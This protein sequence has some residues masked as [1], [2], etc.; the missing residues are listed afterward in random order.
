MTQ[1]EMLDLAGL[2]LSIVFTGSLITSIFIGATSR[3]NRSNLAFV[4]RIYGVAVAAAAANILVN[5][6]D[7]PSD[8]PFWVGLW[9]FNMLM[10]FAG[11]VFNARTRNNI[12]AGSE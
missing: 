5:I 3:P 8:G 11:M 9:T 10:A 1:P 12:S 7:I 2:I 6:A 4:I